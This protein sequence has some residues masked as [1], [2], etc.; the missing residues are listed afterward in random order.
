MIESP[1]S[2]SKQQG[3]GGGVLSHQGDGVGGQLALD[4]AGFGFF[5]MFSSEARTQP[6]GF[7]LW[8]ELPVGPTLC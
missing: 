8:V 2:F 4:A 6:A 5:L 1:V 7:F 3:A